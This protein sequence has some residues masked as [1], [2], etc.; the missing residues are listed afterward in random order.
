MMITNLLWNKG[1]T[2]A[3]MNSVVKKST[4]KCRS[5]GEWSSIRTFIETCLPEKELLFSLR[6]LAGIAVLSS[7]LNYILT[8]SF[9]L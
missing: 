1:R 4:R 9:R 2:Q 5:A 8:T 3:R 6:I 7:Q